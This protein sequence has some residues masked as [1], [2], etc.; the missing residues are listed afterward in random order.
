MNTANN[1]SGAPDAPAFDI[2][3][4]LGNWESFDF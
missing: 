2:A 3:D 4:W 1:T